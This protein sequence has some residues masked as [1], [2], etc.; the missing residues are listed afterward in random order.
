MANKKIKKSPAKKPVAKKIV[1]TAPAKRVMTRTAAPMVETHECQCAH[2][3]CGCHCGCGN[4]FV[5]FCIKLIV[6]AMVFCLGCIAS[7]WVMRNG[8]HM[9]MMRHIQFDNNGC[10]VLET[11]QCPKLLANLATADDNADGCISKVELRHA[12]KEMRH[13]Q[14]PDMPTDPVVN[15]SMAM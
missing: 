9:K 12:M 3:H 6:L 7:P 4:R 13:P 8:G 14:Q 11:V 5:K 2:C 15:D 1:K 10:V